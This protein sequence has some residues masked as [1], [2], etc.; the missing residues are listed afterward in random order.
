M[1]EYVKFWLRIQVWNLKVELH[2]QKDKETLVSIEYYSQNHNAK[3][4]ELHKILDI[5][6]ISLSNGIE[7]NELAEQYIRELSCDK[8]SIVSA[9]IIKEAW[10]EDCSTT[11]RLFYSAFEFSD[12]FI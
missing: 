5:V 7:S 1:S 4:S 10:Q 11:L 9:M 8:Q 12:G 2:I 3:K 6:N